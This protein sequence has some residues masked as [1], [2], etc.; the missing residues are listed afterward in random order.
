MNH[1]LRHYEE[2][3][4]AHCRSCKHPFCTR[5]LVYSY[6]SKK[7]PF[8]VGCALHAGGLRNGP[9]SVPPLP[10][11]APVEAG[12]SKRDLR[13]YRKAEQNAL[14]AEAKAAKRIARK[15]GAKAPEQVPEPVAARSSQD[16]ANAIFA[17]TGAAGTSF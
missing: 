14:K 16:P 2:P 15:G 4:T 8:C 9:R 17:R 13:A 7:P 12:P 6:G 10:V 5:C 1:C 11:A 3:V